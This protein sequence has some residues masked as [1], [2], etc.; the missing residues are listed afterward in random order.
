MAQSDSRRAV[1]TEA[2]VRPQASPRGKCAVLEQVLPCSCP[3]VSI[4]TQVVNNRI[5]I[6]LHR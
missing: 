5:Y 2:P 1:A 3:P 6:I 4:I